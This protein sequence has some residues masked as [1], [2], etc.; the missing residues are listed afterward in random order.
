MYHA[1]PGDLR[2]VN[3]DVHP[4]KPL[5]HSSRASP[6]SF[7]AVST[8]ILLA[9]S[10]VTATLSGNENMIQSPFLIFSI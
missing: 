1:V 9:E 7:F 8:P 6:A 4:A 2:I 3:E 10:A 5:Q